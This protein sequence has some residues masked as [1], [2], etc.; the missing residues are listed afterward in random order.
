MVCNV[1]KVHKYLLMF[2]NVI[3]ILQIFNYCKRNII[4]IL[5]TNM[6]KCDQM[7]TKVNKGQQ[8]LTIFYKVN[9]IVQRGYG[10][11][12]Y[13]RT[14]LRKCLLR[15]NESIWLRL[16]STIP[17]WSCGARVRGLRVMEV[18]L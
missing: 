15:G 10:L 5:L 12:P 4:F 16:T 14:N 9:K 13:W 8:M 7:I 11:T 18:N 17:S 2:T 3:K 6:K 1:N